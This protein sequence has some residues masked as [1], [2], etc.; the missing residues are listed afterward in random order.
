MGTFAP[1]THQRQSSDRP[2]APATDRPPADPCPGPVPSSGLVVGSAHDPAEVEADRVSLEVL[3]RLGSRP[4]A[5]PPVRRVA[6]A[7]IGADGG[8]VSPTTRSAIERLR[9]GGRALPEPV[10]TRMEG[11]FGADFSDVRVH[12]ALRPGR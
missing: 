5:T 2:A 8:A 3:Q 1:H 4:D 10:R 12:P 6:H 11:A 9:S 7:E